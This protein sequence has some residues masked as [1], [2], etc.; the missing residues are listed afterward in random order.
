MPAKQQQLV[1]MCDGRLLVV[2]SY[3]EELAGVVPDAL[4]QAIENDAST[5]WE[6]APLAHTLFR[7]H[8]F[9]VPAPR[10]LAA[11]RGSVLTTRDTT[12]SLAEALAHA[13][14]PTR[15][16]LLRQ[17]GVIVRQIHEAGYRLPTNES[18]AHAL[19]VIAGTELVTLANVE[20]LEERPADWQTL[21]RSELPLQGRER[22][23]VS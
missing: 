21:A 11:S 23:V 4:M 6:L 14:F 9:G 13:S 7:L 12:T 10:L 8:R 19:G 22:Q 16:R 20:L 17:A 18:W 3:F 5:R 15:S 1:P 2:R